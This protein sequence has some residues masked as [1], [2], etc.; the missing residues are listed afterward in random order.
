MTVNKRRIFIRQT[1]LGLAGAGMINSMDLNAFSKRPQAS[2][3]V[4]VGLIGCRGMGFW[5]LKQQLALA[6]VKC[7]AICDVD[8]N[9]MEEK[10]AE[11]EKDYAQKPKKYSDFRKLIEHKDLDAVVIGTPDHWHC[12]PM[13]Y[14]CEAGLAVYVE[15]PMAN[16]IEEC[17][18]MVKAADRYNSVVQVGQ[19]Q[20]SGQQWLEVMSRIKSGDLGKLRKVEIWANFNYGVGAQRVP[21]TPVPAGIDYDMWLGPAPDRETFNTSRFHGNWR[22]HWDYGGGLITDWGVHLIDMALWAGDV[23]NPPTEVLANGANL[24]FPDNN[25]ETYDTMSVIWPQKDYII[26]WNHTAG[27]QLGPDDMAYGLR[28]IC[29]NATIIANRE[30]WKIVP[31]MD[32]ET[33]KVEPYEF[34]EGRQNHDH[35][36]RNFIESI[37]SNNRATACTPAIGRQVALYAH[38][39]NIAVRSGEG[40]LIWDETKNQFIGS[41]KANQYVVPEYRKPWVLPKI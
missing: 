5:V 3:I 24:S 37:K 22:M 31:E 16:S 15:K 1:S 41:E 18:L 30:S 19:Q 13:V 27:T 29:D 17:N 23:I 38:M 28:F 25:H 11:L 12:L 21:D 6:D 7:V 33:P 20:R 32:G 8:Q 14:A 40:R 9:I 10:V 35:H 4:N 36:S 26:S 39:A 34:K 2:D